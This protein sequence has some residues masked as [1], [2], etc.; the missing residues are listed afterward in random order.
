MPTESSLDELQRIQ[1]NYKDITRRFTGRNVRENCERVENTDEDFNTESIEEEEGA[2]TAMM[3]EI[4]EGRD[5]DIADREM[6]E[7]DE[8]EEREGL[9]MENALKVETAYT[10]YMGFFNGFTNRKEE[11]IG[12]M[13]ETAQ[14]FKKGA[15]RDASRILE[16]LDEDISNLKDAEKL[17]R[18]DEEEGRKKLSKT[19]PTLL[20]NSEASI[21]LSNNIQRRSKATKQKIENDREVVREAYNNVLRYLDTNSGDVRELKE[22]VDDFL[23]GWGDEIK[24]TANRVRNTGMKGIT[25]DEVKEYEVWIGGE[26]E[27]EIYKSTSKEEALKDFLD[28]NYFEGEEKL[29]VYVKPEDWKA[30]GPADQPERYIVQREEPCGWEI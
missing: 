15:C 6:G 9:Y 7:T 18:Q 25:R 19:L 17:Y 1:E 16:K 5:K 2:L 21:N 13:R 23:L 3:A 29:E 14:D 28:T 11:R 22:S 26:D 4:N 30:T 8:E 20:G 10:R 12:R 27:R 24:R